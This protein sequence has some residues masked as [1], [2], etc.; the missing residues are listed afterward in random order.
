MNAQKRRFQAEIFEA[1][2][3]LPQLFGNAHGDRV[4]CVALMNPELNVASPR[5][6]V[7]TIR[8]AKLA[9][10]ELWVMFKDSGGVSKADGGPNECEQLEPLRLVW[11][12]LAAPN[13]SN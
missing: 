2:P 7:E 4:V 3:Q 10:G 6:V 11:E 5:E 12:K 1:L 13:S 9:G 8:K